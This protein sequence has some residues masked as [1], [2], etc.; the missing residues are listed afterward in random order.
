[1]K[2]LRPPPI[3][4]LQRGLVWTSNRNSTR[5]LVGS[6][7]RRKAG[8]NQPRKT[9]NAGELKVS[10]RA[11]NSVAQAARQVASVI[12]SPRRLRRWQRT[13][14]AGVALTE[15]RQFRKL[16]V[17]GASPVTGPISYMISMNKLTEIEKIVGKYFGDVSYYGDPASQ[18]DLA[19]KW[20]HQALVEVRKVLDR[21][22]KG[23]GSGE[24]K[25]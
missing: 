16:D 12:I 3:K 17:A 18:R 11:I 19:P 15:E 4:S 7:L 23:P 2:I 24:R 1:M 10:A 21:T 22:E 6:S 14:N 20:A 25:K 8:S 5:H 13:I 9:S